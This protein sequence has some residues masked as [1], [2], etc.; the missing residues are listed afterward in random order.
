MCCNNS[1]INYWLQS[2][3]YILFVNSLNSWADCYLK[4]YNKPDITDSEDLSMKKAIKSKF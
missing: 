4:G 1:T 3:N 2:F